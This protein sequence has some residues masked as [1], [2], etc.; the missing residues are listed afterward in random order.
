ME[1]LATLLL[2]AST[3]ALYLSPF[4]A[5]PAPA[6]A[7]VGEAALVSL[8]C[9]AALLLSGPAHAAVSMESA[10]AEAADA[11]YPILRAATPASVS[12]LAD[13][14]GQASPSDLAKAIDL[15]P[16]VALTVPA[17]KAAAASAALSA[18]VSEL[19]P[20]T[21]A[22]FPLPPTVLQSLQSLQTAA[23]PTK[24][25]AARKL[26][27]PT[28]PG[29]EGSICL[30]PRASL[31][32]LVLA[33]ANALAAADA[34]TLNAFEAQADRAF[35][36]IPIGARVAELPTLQVQVGELSERRTLKAALA[37]VDTARKA[38]TSRKR[39]AEAPLSA[40]SQQLGDRSFRLGQANPWYNRGTG[41]R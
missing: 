2:T 38:D 35:K 5:R 8:C 11:S 29:N 25:A 28:L 30:P 10:L 17:D 7:D 24:L 23:D 31:K 34:A 32:T 27:P 19:S 12:K 18:A 4:P 36:S 13:L 21:C 40:S 14:A 9:S 16:D 15:G 26:L 33:N 41:L 6:R 39:A 1:A 37:K 3:T 20:A 22:L